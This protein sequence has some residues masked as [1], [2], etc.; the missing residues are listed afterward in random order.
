MQA[1][2]A[3]AK[4]MQRIYSW[5]QTDDGKRNM[6]D[7]AAAATKAGSA[8]STV[9]NAADM[10]AAID[11]FV[12]VQRNMPKDR[13]GFSAHLKKQCET[14]SQS[15]SKLLANVARILPQHTEVMFG[16]VSGYR[17]WLRGEASA[18]SPSIK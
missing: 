2:V 10:Q 9:P 8:A 3:E 7:A 11:F 5:Q 14:A 6:A 12:A 16:Y 15:Q 18:T 13:A 4:Q 1:F 17:A